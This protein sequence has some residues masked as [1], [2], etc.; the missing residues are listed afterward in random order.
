M[1][2]GIHEVTFHSW[3]LPL[4]LAAFSLYLAQ[5][6]VQSLIFGSTARNPII[7]PLIGFIFT[8]FG[9]AMFYERGQ[10]T[11]DVARRMVTWHRTG[12]AGTQK[13]RFAFA[14]IRGAFAWKPNREA[15][16]RPGNES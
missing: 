1:G 13:G 15:G 11:F 10:F 3:K 2:H 14:A 12:V 8:G 16:L 7:G 5:V 9:A 6:L 4:F